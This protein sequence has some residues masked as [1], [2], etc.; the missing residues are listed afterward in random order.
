[1]VLARTDHSAVTCIAVLARRGTGVT[2]HA[3]AVR[4][5]SSWLFPRGVTHTLLRTSWLVSAVELAARYFMPGC[6]SY[7]GL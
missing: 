4:T 1:M 5:D 6:T 7:L 3:G 2:R